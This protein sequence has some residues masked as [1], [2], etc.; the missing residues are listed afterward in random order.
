MCNLIVLYFF[1]SATHLVEIYHNLAAKNSD[2]DEGQLNKTKKATTRCEETQVDINI[3]NEVDKVPP[4][5]IP[6][7]V[8]PHAETNIDEPNGLRCDRTTRI[9][10][11]YNPPEAPRTVSCYSK[12]Y[13]LPTIASRMKQ[14]A[15]Y[16]LN[17][18]NFKVSFKI[19]VDLFGFFGTY[20]II[21]FFYLGQVKLR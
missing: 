9:G 19:T 14:A 20:V 15:K 10:D 6:N 4:L 21:Y 18:F 17:T 1:I 8:N 7:R 12:N 2:S 3:Q 5:I 16:Y 11:A 13:E